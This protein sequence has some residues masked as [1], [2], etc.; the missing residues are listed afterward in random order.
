[1]DTIKLPVQTRSERGNGPSRRLRANG[2]IP[3]VV[4]GKGS[5]A[6]PITVAFEDFKAAMAQGHNV[7]LELGL[8]TKTR[9]ARKG[10]KS[11]PGPL[12]AVVKELQFHPTKRRLLHIDLHEVDLSVEIEAAVPLEL[13]GTP[14]GVVDGGI[15]DWEHREVNVRA[16]PTDIPDKMELDVS[17]LEV[18]QNITVAALVAGEGVAI[19]DDPETMIAA[20]LAPRLHEEEEALAAEEEFEEGL[21][22]EPELIGEESA[23]E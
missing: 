9:S 21:E 2:H 12:Y 10:G 17:E 23:E 18:G 8:D 11:R 20:V 16:L 15:L 5:D 3:G 7:V 1:M 19:V 22:P 13:I 6:T 4:Y 14:A